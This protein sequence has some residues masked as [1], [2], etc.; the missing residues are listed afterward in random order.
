MKMVRILTKQWKWSE[1]LL[2]MTNL[3]LQKS[4]KLWGFSQNYKIFRYTTL[5]QKIQNISKY[6]NYFWTAKPGKNIFGPPSP[7]KHFWTAKS[8]NPFLDCQTHKK[9]LWKK[10]LFHFT[11]AKLVIQ[12]KTSTFFI[13]T[14]IHVTPQEPKIVIQSKTSNFLIQTNIPA[15]PHLTRI[16]ILLHTWHE[17]P[18]YSTRARPPLRGAPLACPYIYIY[19]SY[20]L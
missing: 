13:L 17:Y 3:K 15:T 6:K 10:Y 7:K 18:S 19:I 16:F 12:S 2:K 5:G 11:R 9:S 1:S 8:E 4:P 20:S 14:K